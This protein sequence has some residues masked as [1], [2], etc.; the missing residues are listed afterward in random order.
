[1]WVTLVMGSIVLASAGVIQSSSREIAVVKVYDT[2]GEPS[3]GFQVRSAPYQDGMAVSAAV[4]LRKERGVAGKDGIVIS[5]FGFYAWEE[6]DVIHVR[7]FALVPQ[8]GA[9][10]QYLWGADSTRGQLVPRLFASHTMPKKPHRKV[11]HE[12]KSLGVT[13]MELELEVISR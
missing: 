12:M 11:I 4:P 3:V 10:N 8:S 7:I 13:P 9:P 5:A 2:G 1:M 6:R